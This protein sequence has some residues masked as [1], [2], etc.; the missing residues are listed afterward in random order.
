MRF[1]PLPT[2]AIKPAGWLEKQLKIQGDGL[3]GHL[4]EFWPDIQKSSWFGGDAEGW[5]RVP[6]W[7]DGIVPLAYQLDDKNLQA[8]IKRAVDYIL[9]HQNADGW[10]G[11]VGDNNPRH[12]PYDVW[13]LFPLFKAFIQYQ[14][15]TG[16]ERVIPAL[17][18]CAKKI[19]QVITKEPLYSWAHYRAADFA[20][21]LYWLSQK[22]G[23]MSLV[24]LARKVMSQAYDWRT[25]FE[26]FADKYTEKTTQFGLDNHGVNNGM[27]LK[28]GPVRWRLSGDEKDRDLTTLMLAMLDRYHGQATG[29]FTCDEHYAGRSPSQGTELCTV[30]ES[31]YSLALGTAATGDVALA[32]RWERLAYNALPA[33]FKKDMSAHQYD[34]QCNQVLCSRE[35]EHVYT[36]NGPD[37]NLYGLEPNFGCCTANMH[38]GWPKFVAKLWMKPSD[39]GLAAIGYA[40]C[41]L[42][43]KLSGKPVEIDVKTEYPFR[44]VIFIKVT[45]TQANTFPIYLRLPKWSSMAHILF[46]DC[47]VNVD[48]A[49]I[50]AP[51]GGSLVSRPGGS[52]LKLDATWEGETTFV[53]EFRDPIELYRGANDS[54]AVLQGPLVFALPLVAEW[55]CIN[56]RPGLPFD[57]W[58]VS[59]NT[60]WNYALEIDRDNPA[61]SVRVE[62]DRRGDVPF[63]P[64]TPTTRVKVK[65]RRF[66]SW[67]LEKSAASPPPQSP[68]SSDEP[69]EEL[70]LVPYGT[71]DLRLTEFP[72]LNATQQGNR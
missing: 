45:A 33:T 39:G 11:P 32:D 41:H 28:F 65:G 27:A 36:N 69:L 26:H 5:E 25:H 16:D 62:R 20:I 15:A 35:G 21:C 50:E 7:L 13:P 63:L 14:E 12:K 18:K 29:T 31:M 34:Q 1:E 58:E 43:T 59:T 17:V 6:Y 55:K 51:E 67:T 68:V 38:Q 19:D 48:G 70:T 8:K 4:D 66:P 30:V 24:E 22:T 61:N 44:N 54:L 49:R 46:K 60:P 42:Q 37:A 52:F 9:G 53:I 64:D 2:G 56:D 72:I 10:L 23:D 71:T 3:S 40:P 47:V 57:D